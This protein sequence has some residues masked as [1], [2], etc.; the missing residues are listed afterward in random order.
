MNTGLAGRPRSKS[1]RYRR[2]LTRLRVNNKGRWYNRV[3]FEIMA[4]LFWAETGLQPPH[5]G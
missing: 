2:P 4:P 5:H 1:K 3:D